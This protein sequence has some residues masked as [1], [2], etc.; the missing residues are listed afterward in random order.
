MD[1]FHL[2]EMLCQSL[3]DHVTVGIHDNLLNGIHC[4][5]GIE[6]MMEKGF[7]RPMA[8]IFPVSLAEWCRMGTS[9]VIF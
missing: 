9:A 3:K 6:N 7:T 5:Q 8:I 4:L 1:G 2:R